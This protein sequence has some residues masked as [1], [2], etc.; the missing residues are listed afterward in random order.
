MSPPYSRPQAFT[1]LELII[2]IIVISIIAAVFASS[3]GTPLSNRISAAGYKIRSDIRYAQSYALASQRRTRIG[4]EFTGAPGAI[5]YS[6]YAEQTPN[7]DDWVLIKDPLT[8]KDY[9]VDFSQG[10]YSL[11]GGIYSFFN[12]DSYDLVFD[13][14]GAPWGYNQ[15]DGSETQLSSDGTVSVYTATFTVARVKPNTGKVSG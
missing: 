5:S 14:E 10:E 1:L 15:S 11:I 7:A 8:R 13:K 3:K 9:R 2:T 12:Q 4:F 6:I